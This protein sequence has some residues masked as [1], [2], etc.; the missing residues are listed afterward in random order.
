M[1][2][3]KACLTTMLMALTLLATACPDDPP[4][5]ERPDAGIQEEFAALKI[6]EESKNLLFTYLLADGSFATV[7]RVSEVPDKARGQVIVVDTS[8]SP[9]ER[10]SSQVLYVADLTSKRADGSYSYSLVSRFKFERDLLRDPA[11]KSGVLPPECEMMAESPDDRI[12]MYSTD[13]CGVCKTAARF[14]RKQGIPFEEKDVEKDPAAQR[15]LSC[16]ALKAGTPI[17]GVPV[18][19]AAGQLLVGFE[20]DRLVMA[21]RRLKRSPTGPA[22]DRGPK[23]P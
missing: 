23:P 19:D 17:N 10:Q 2:Q 13:W 11:A 22:T 15:E 7:E 16:K 5:Q 14:M 12:I 18:L 8:L 6:N 9:Q 3:S 1:M 4:G 20:R 21:A